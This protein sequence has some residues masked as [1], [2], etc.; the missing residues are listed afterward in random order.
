MQIHNILEADLLD[1]EPGDS[2]PGVAIG[3]QTSTEKD[4]AI[5]LAT[6]QA[7][8][9]VHKPIPKMSAKV[10][11]CGLAKGKMWVQNCASSLMLAGF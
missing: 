7:S 8:P 6:M 1:D 9:M 11:Q 3:H 2:K 10:H 5:T 4:V